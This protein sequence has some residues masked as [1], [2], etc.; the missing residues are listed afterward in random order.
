MLAT[1][2]LVEVRLEVEDLEL[3]PG[4]GYNL[5]SAL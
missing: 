1:I 3:A 5:L 4:V 2:I